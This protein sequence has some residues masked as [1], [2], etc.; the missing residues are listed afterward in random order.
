[1]QVFAGIRVCN[2]GGSQ[3]GAVLDLCSALGMPE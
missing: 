1:M 3:K 2:Q